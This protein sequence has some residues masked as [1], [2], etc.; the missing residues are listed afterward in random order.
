MTDKEKQ[1]LEGY[2]QKTLNL[3]S[4]AVAGLYNEA[5]ELT[6]VEPIITADAS[7]VAKFKSEK[8]QQLDRGFKEG[9]ESYEKEIKEKFGVDSDLQGLDLIDHVLENKTLEL[10]E[11]VLKSNKIKDEDF[12]KH[13]KYIA[14]KSE[15]DKALKNKDKEWEDKLKTK[16]TEWQK[17][18]TF[19]KVSKVALTEIE[20]NY[21]MPENADRALAIKEVLL[22][23]LGENNFSIQE[24]GSIIILDKSGKPCEDA[25]GHI[26]NFKEYINNLSVKFLD[27]K[28][29]NARGSAANQGGGASGGQSAIKNQDDFLQ[30]MKSA[31]TSEERIKIKQEF[32]KLK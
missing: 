31:K 15:H 18:E 28:V 12:E 29:A 2:F 8:K 11:K 26:L 5:G 20:T 24:D 9:R 4:E 6:T 7:R 22:G 14:L 25:H 10:N 30:A 13:P 3:D 23:K 27:K 32:D 21:L 1:L 17:Q 16:E 19:N